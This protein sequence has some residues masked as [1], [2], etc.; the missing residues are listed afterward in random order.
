MDLIDTLFKNDNKPTES[1]PCAVQFCKAT[2]LVNR[3]DNQ[4]RTPL[5]VAIAFH[6]K[7]AAETLILLGA[8][9]HIQDCYGQRPIDICFIEGL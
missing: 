8:N 1:I 3:R 9:P 2:G 6:N 4:G 7:V 5:H